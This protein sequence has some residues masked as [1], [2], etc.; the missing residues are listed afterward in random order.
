M[1]T[2]NIEVTASFPEPFVEDLLKREWF[3]KLYESLEEFVCDATRRLKE[4]YLKRE[5][6]AK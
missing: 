6:E 1:K 4:Y 5:A 3:K 2:R